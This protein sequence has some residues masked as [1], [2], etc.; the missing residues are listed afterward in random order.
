MLMNAGS[1]FRMSNNVNFGLIFGSR[2]DW[3]IGLRD[4]KTSAGEKGACVFL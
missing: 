4:P 3:K 1:I 2:R